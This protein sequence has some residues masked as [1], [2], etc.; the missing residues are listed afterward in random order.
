MLE[1]VYHTCLAYRLK[2]KGVRVEIE[3]PIPV[4]F[5]ALK[6]DCGYRADLVIENCIVVETKNIDAIGSIHIAQMLTYLRFL[7]MKNGLILNFKTVL[8][9]DGIKRVVNGF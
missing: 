2:S 7:K 9:K 5:E 3:K 6:M 4:Y 8:M 1:S